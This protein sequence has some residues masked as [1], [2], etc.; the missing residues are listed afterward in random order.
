MFP[1][2]INYEQITTTTQKAIDYVYATRNGSH[3]VIAMSR[4]KPQGDDF[5][6]GSAAASALTKSNAVV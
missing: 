6:L 5:K 1:V 3:T 2:R 4:R